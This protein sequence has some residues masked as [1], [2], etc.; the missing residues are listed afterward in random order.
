MSQKLTGCCNQTL[1][2]LRGADRGSAR[3]ACI[4]KHVPLNRDVLVS[5][6]LLGHLHVFNGL[7]GHVLRNVLPQILNGVVVS[8]SD[9]FRDLL[10]LT[11]FPVLN[12]L[13][14]LGDTL[15][16]GLVLVFDNLLLKGH[17]LDP[18]LTFDHILAGADG[19]SNGSASHLLGGGS[20]DNSSVICGSGSGA[21]I[22]CN[23]GGSGIYIVGSSSGGLVSSVHRVASLSVNESAVCH[24]NKIKLKSNISKVFPTT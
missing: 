24:L 17:I 20:T 13:D 1:S 9:L 12:L 10:D 3:F 2:Q 7:L 16:L 8:N 18:A 5:H 4:S 15:K 21:S 11:L 14:G 22:A 23:I 6:V 19:S